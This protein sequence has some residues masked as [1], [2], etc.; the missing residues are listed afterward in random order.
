MREKDKQE[1]EVLVI[2]SAARHAGKTTLCH[3]LVRDLPFKTYI[4]L[5]RRS[6]HLTVLSS[7]AGT[8][9]SSRG[10]T[11]RIQ[12]LQR[13]PG[14][15]T[16]TEL[17]LVDGPREETD[18]AIMHLLQEHSERPALVEGYCALPRQWAH[19]LFVLPC[20]LPATVKPDYVERA[21]QADLLVVNCFPTCPPAEEN[22]MLAFLRDLCPETAQLA[23][24]AQDP[25][26]FETMKEMLQ[27]LFPCFERRD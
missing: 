26:F 19:Y 24:S 2:H 12:E 25:F 5:S 6:P 4:K 7:V 18:A 13:R 27:R 1:A 20:P 11:S 23:G 22:A 21:R 17:A 3:A 8:L 15:P 9:P 14:L 16:L 10:D